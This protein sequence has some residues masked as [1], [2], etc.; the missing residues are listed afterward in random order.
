[1]LTETQLEQQASIVVLHQQ[2]HEIRTAK[3]LTEQSNQLNNIVSTQKAKIEEQEKMLNTLVKTQVERQANL[4]T[5]IKMQQA[6]IDHFIQVIYLYIYI[7][8][9]FNHF[10]YLRHYQDNQVFQ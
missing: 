7:E 3:I 9:N 2:E 8:F 1:M 5:Q 6:K 10:N 4:D